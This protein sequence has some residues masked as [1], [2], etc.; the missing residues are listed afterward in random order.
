MRELIGLG[1][2]D[3]L[4]RL[5]PDLAIWRVRARLAYYRSRYVA[6]RGPAGLFLSIQDTLATLQARGFDLAVAT[7]KSRRGLDSALART[8]V[9][10]YF[11]VTRCADES[12][13]KPAPDLIKDIL[14]R[15]ATPPVNALMIGDTEYDM[16]MGR[17]AGV[18]ALGVRCGVHNVGRLRLAGAMDVL[19]SVALLPDWL[20]RKARPPVIMQGC[21]N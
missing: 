17:A 21:E 15:T 8:G 2:H 12:A 16:A 5:F 14:L 3:V 11:K 9:A 13:P 20:A 10:G 7:G 18:D 4:A 19:D 1:F 6:L